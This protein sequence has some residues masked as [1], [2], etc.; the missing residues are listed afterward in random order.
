MNKI[1]AA[2]MIYKL[3]GQN[4]ERM[5]PA[6]VESSKYKIALNRLSSTMS[7]T[8]LDFVSYCWI[9]SFTNDSRRLDL[10]Y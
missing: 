3:I 4:D 1:A 9:S 2:I 10:Y 5:N 8:N 7:L 6:E